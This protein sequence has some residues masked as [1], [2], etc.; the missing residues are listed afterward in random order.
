DL[1][2][3]QLPQH[4]NF[5]HTIFGVLTGGFDIFR[6]LMSTPT[7]SSTDKPIT[8]EVIN[9][10]VVFTDTQNGVLRVHAP[11]GFTGSTTL[12]I[13]ADDGHGST[14]QKQVAVNVVADT[15]NDRA[16][17]G[18]VSNQTTDVG[19]PVTFQVQG[20]DLENDSLTYF[21]KDPNSFPSD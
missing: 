19:K 10:A 5:Q 3:A 1:P 16:F 11:A 8:N 7:N 15:V 20:I 13:T 12:T 17:L 18:P 21:V 6:K 4:L 14:N 9:S 2:L